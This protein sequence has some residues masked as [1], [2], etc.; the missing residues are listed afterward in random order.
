MNIREYQCTDSFLKKYITHITL[1]EFEQDNLDDGIK[2]PPLGFPVIQ[3]H[4]G[5]KATFYNRPNA[6]D[7]AMIIGQVTDYVTLTPSTGTKILGVNF[8]PY[9]FY[10]LFSISPLPLQNTLIHAKNLFGTE[11]TG[12][13]LSQM[14][15]AQTDTE[16]I[17]LASNLLKKHAKKFQQ[18]ENPL[19]DKIVRTIIN[20]NGLVKINDIVP[21]NS[22]IRTL[23]RYFRHHLGI[24]PKLFTAI[25]RHRFIIHQLSA[26]PE[27][28]WKH[29]SLDAYF[30]DQSHYDRDFQKFS[31][32]KPLYYDPESNQLAAFLA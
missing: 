5:K 7:E 32:Q 14:K 23:Q 18:T 17:L 27:F 22:N 21:G 29:P 6:P 13:T 2:V 10:N 20:K 24:S 1:L 15:S 9:G 3:F 4:Y 26:E 16:L 8:K 31:G 25:L 28:D 19:F 11:D 30:F 12:L